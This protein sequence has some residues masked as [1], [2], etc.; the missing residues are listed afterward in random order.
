M[1]SLQQFNRIYYVENGVVSER[2]CK[3]AFL[4]IFGISNG[5]LGRALALET[6]E[7]GAPHRDQRRCHVPVNKTPE[8]KIEQIKE[9]ISKF[10]CYKSHYSRQYNPNCKYLSPDISISKMYALYKEEQGEQAVSEW[11]YRQV[12]NSSFNLTFGR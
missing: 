11:K 9:H 10:P 1:S 2:V 3:T 7:G 8:E 6:A 5:L 12:F 4:S